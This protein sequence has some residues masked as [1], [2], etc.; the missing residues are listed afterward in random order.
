MAGGLLSKRRFK[1]SR[2]KPK[3]NQRRRP[4][5]CYTLV[6][7]GIISKVIEKHMKNLDYVYLSRD[8]L[9]V[10]HGLVISETAITTRKCRLV[11]KMFDNM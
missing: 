5:T 8:E 10:K 9:L 7:S 1:I 11:R 3:S 4:R 2:S 6:E